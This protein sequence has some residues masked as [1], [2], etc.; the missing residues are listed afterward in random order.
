MVM[1]RLVT[2]KRFIKDPKD[3][4][5]KEAAIGLS[6][7]ATRLGSIDQFDKRGNVVFMDDFEDPCAMDE[8]KYDS[9]V[10]GT[11]AWVA[12]S[13]VT[14]LSGS[15]SV[16]LTTGDSEDDYARF[17]KRFAPP[18]Y[19]RMSSEIAFQYNRNLKN[20]RIYISIYDGT[21]YYLGQV[22]T[23]TS[24]SSL[25]V[26]KSDFTWETFASGMKVNLND[27]ISL[28][29]HIKLVIDLAN[30]KYVRCLLDDSEYD[31]SSYSLY[32]SASATRPR[33]SCAFEAEWFWWW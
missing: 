12:R 13:N 16:C 17:W 2:S 22:Q 28:F 30:M 7:L 9:Y 5:G 32:T 26:R 21:N 31:L 24:T 15:Y 18:I 33:L 29:H 11:G 19:K 6:E 14:S 1:V 8:G 4:W 27:D 3:V 20:F 25:Q 23:V 10:K